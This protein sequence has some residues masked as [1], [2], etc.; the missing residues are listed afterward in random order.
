M[1]N[2]IYRFHLKRV[3]NKLTVA[4]IVRKIIIR[5]VAA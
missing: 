3:D 1:K 2:V 5:R 4:S